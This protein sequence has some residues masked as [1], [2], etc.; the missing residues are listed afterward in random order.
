MNCVKKCALGYLFACAS[1]HGEVK[2][3]GVPYE[4]LKPQIKPL[5]LI[6]FRG[7]DFV[8]K[9]IQDFENEVLGNGD[10]SHCG[11]VLTTEIVPIKNGKPG[12]LY[13]WESTF[14]LIKDVELN[15]YVFGVQIRLLEDVIH[16]YNKGLKTRIGWCKL[17]QNPL[18]IKET[19]EENEEKVYINPK[20]CEI[21]QEL[22]KEYNHSGYNYEPCDLI[23]TVSPGCSTCCRCFCGW[24]Y[25]YFNCC[26]ISCLYCCDSCSGPKYKIP[27]KKTFYNDVFS[28]HF[29]S[30][31]MLYKLKKEDKRAMKVRLF[32]SELVALCYIKLGLWPA[33][34][35]PHNIAPVEFLGYTNE[36]KLPVIVESPIIIS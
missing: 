28:R 13:I 20:V 4:E 30:K 18:F 36:K 33:E 14:D 12:E 31:G 26:C 2:K 19:K 7:S 16:E 32:C 17:K 34:I 24:L 22:Y 6:L 23:S 9:C 5:D 35:Q 3:E 21:M 8:S 15:D 29:K 25:Y 27:I 11:L 10:W 1:D